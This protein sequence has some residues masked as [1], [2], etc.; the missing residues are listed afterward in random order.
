MAAIEAK[1]YSGKRICKLCRRT[2]MPMEMYYKR[3]AGKVHV[4]CARRLLTAKREAG[5][6]SGREERIMASGNWQADAIDSERERGPFVTG[7]ECPVCHETVEVEDGQEEVVC[8][9]CDTELEVDHDADM[10]EG[11][12]V[13][14]SRLVSKRRRGT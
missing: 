9:K 6:K 11:R 7:Y 8:W 2:I 5:S 4:A 1:W 12:R 10:G 14:L 3:P 13:D